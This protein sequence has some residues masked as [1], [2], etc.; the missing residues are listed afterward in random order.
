M[1]ITP[2]RLM[3]NVLT[4]ITMSAIILGLSSVPVS[5]QTGSILYVNQ[6][7]QSAN[8]NNPGTVNAPL[9]TINGA[10]NKDNSYV[11]IVISPGTYREQVVLSNAS[12]V[13]IDGGSAN[14]VKISAFNL[15]GGWR[16]ESDGSKSALVPQL[17]RASNAWPN[18]VTIPFAASFRSPVYA[19]GARLNPIAGGTPN[20]MQYKLVTEGSQDRIYLRNTATVEFGVRQ[21]A[22][23]VNNSSKIVI[24][25]LSVEGCANNISIEGCLQVVNSQDLTIENITASRGSYSGIQIMDSKRVTVKN[26]YG[27]H[28]GV[29]GFGAASSEDIVLDG[30]RLHN[31]GWRTQQFNGSNKHLAYWDGGNKW[32]TCIRCKILNTDVQDTDGPGIWLD[33]RNIS[34]LVENTKIVRSSGAGIFVEAHCET[35]SVILRNLTIEH[36]I[37]RGSDKDYI[38]GDL[39]MT[40]SN[41]VRYEN[42]K[43]ISSGLNAV[44]FNNFSRNVGSCAPIQAKD[45][46]FSGLQIERTTN[47]NFFNFAAAS[48]GYPA[49][50]LVDAT[51]RGSGGYRVN[52]SD[53]DRNT[54]LSRIKSGSQIT[55]GSGT[56]PT[57]GPTSA[58]TQAPTAQPSTAPNEPFGPYSGTS[59][60]LP[61]T[62]EA[63]NFNKGGQNSAYS[64]K[65]TQNE[66]G[67][68]RQTS[69]D[70]KT[71]AAKTIVGWFDNG[72]WMKYSVN[73]PKTANYVLTPT[74]GSITSGYS[75]RIKSGDRLL[76]VLGVPK[77]N[78]WTD[79]LQTRNVLVR[80]QKGQSVFTI[81]SVGGFI[82]L[83]K[84]EVKDADTLGCLRAD[85]NRD[86]I[87]DLEDYNLLVKDFLKT[88]QD[89]QLADANYDGVIDLEDY[90]LLVNEFFQTQNSACK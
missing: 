23:Q 5:A 55:V 90:S 47:G 7:H 32:F 59:I 15:I 52:G 41:A 36:T 10:L 77:L 83:D 35:P 75:M 53:I 79:P 27:H 40:G 38:N 18:D 82:D 33:W 14:S 68:Y 70:I 78:T 69:V 13:T 4:V 42:V 85:I 76:G 28:N 44:L 57:S 81:E 2:Q 11:T 50:T 60:N 8:D 67:E 71:N 30:A 22:M 46:V 3:M 1:M 26:I 45:N 39:F 49:T 9:K 24:K 62:I 16:D 87:V 63:E 54:F 61:G 6:S 31:N 21:Y 20:N 58:P 64:D 74:F 88:G 73:V 89:F 29:R 51:V 84:V 66:G 65:T 25:N 17:S 80:V 37:S 12:R 56:L 86:G 43:I 19:N 72:E 48:S 34:F